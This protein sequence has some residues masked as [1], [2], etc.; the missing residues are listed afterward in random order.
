LVSKKRM[1]QRKA[2]LR[3]DPLSQVTIYDYASQP[4]TNANQ[5]DLD[6]ELIR[7][8]WFNKKWMINVIRIGAFLSFISISMNTPAT[9]EM[10]PTVLYILFVIDLLCSLLFTTEMIIKIKTKGLY[11]D[12][13]SYMFDRWCQ[14]DFCMLL[15]HWISVLIQVYLISTPFG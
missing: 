7:L 10:I 15:F 4:N 11:R 9:I 2:S 8:G 6:N 13:N 1:I 12:E 3:A 14:F 5:D